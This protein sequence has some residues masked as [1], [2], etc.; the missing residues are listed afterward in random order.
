[1]TSRK[2][3][4]VTGNVS[5]N[6]G[7]SRSFFELYN[8]WNSN[9]ESD[10]LAVGIH[11]GRVVT[12]QKLVSLKQVSSESLKFNPV[13]YGVLFKYFPGLFN[14]WLVNYIKRKRSY[15]LVVLNVPL[16]LEGSD[17]K[18]LFHHNGSFIKIR[19][20]YDYLGKT[21]S[22]NQLSLYWDGRLFQSSLQK[23]RSI[24]ASRELQ[25]DV[26]INPVID[27]NT[28]SK[29]SNRG[30]SESI[31][32]VGSIQER[33]GYM[34]LIPLLDIIK[35]NGLEVTVFGEIA[36]RSYYADL[37]SLIESLGCSGLIS[38]RGFSKNYLDH[39]ASAS[40]VIH[41]AHDEGVS[42]TVREAA[43]LG[44]PILCYRIDGNIEVLGKNYLLMSDL[45]DKVCLRNKL[46]DFLEARDKRKYY[47]SY[48]KSF[49]KSNYN[50]SVQEYIRTLGL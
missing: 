10:I 18:V 50:Q 41:L 4:F 17:V 43:Y 14:K 31:I 42:R 1:M 16:T 38:F 8:A 30:V 6:N 46:K 26:T 5:L 15:S 20:S 34:D 2:V 28:L 49:L 25:Y 40:L 33:K 48:P 32:M 39:L 21:L 27:E 36:D 22:Y 35:N 3:L 11:L 12:R 37:Q 44:K 9:V 24:N 45:G 19:S 13:I 23:T 29:I 7:G 47:S